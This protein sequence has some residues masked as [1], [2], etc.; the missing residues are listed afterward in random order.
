M[1]VT[2]AAPLRTSDLA[3]GGM[4]RVPRN[5]DSGHA[6]HADRGVG[7]VERLVAQF[8]L[9][10]VLMEFYERDQ[11][12]VFTLR[13]RGSSTNHARFREH[14]LLSDQWRLGQV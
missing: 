9:R 1:T 3:V 10:I 8:G 14:A 13:A 5:D 7:G 12:V 2:A 4:V 11:Q 6:R